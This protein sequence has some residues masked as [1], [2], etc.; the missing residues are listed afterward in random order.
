MHTHLNVA[1]VA[2]AENAAMVCLQ[3]IFFHFYLS[4]LFVKD[5][6]RTFPYSFKQ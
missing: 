5:Q 4:Y 3:K 1:K 2:A 6:A